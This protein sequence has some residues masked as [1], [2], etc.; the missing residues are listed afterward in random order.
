MSNDYQ[1]P[2][3]EVEDSDEDREIL[4]EATSRFETIQ[5][6]D[7]DNRDNYKADTKFVYSPGN[8][9]PD[10]VRATRTQWKE[11][12]LEFNQLK[13][14]VAQ[15]VNDQRQNRP[16][17]RIHPASGE[18]SEEVAEILQGLI[19]GI[20][21]QSNAEACY[22]NAFQ[23]AVA[24]NRGA[25]RIYSEYEDENSFNQRLCIKPIN[26]M[27]SVWADLNYQQP[28][29]SD[30]DFVFVTEKYTKTEFRNKFPKAQEISWDAVD[31]CWCDGKDTI[32]VADYYRRVCNKR[33]M[34]L[35]SDGAQG[36]KDEMPKPPEGVEIVREREVEHYTVQWFTLAGGQQILARYDW[37]GSIIPVVIVPG[38]DFIID[39]K[40]VYQSLT[41]HARDAQSMLN[42]GM[43]QQAIHLA[44]SPRAPWVAAE[45]Q[46]EGYENIWRDANTRNYSVLPY[47]PTSIDGIVVP[48]PQRT[49]PTMPDAG[50]IQFNQAMT[51]MIKSTIGMYEQSLGQR[52]NEQSGK[53]ILA[54]ERQ[55]DT[56][57]FNYSDNL[58]RGIA[59][60][61]RILVEAIP[62]Y[63]DTARIVQ[64][65]GPDETQK[66][67]EIN[68]TM[69]D[70]SN[71]LQAI[72][73]NDV[74]IGRYAVTCQAGPS[75]ATKK[76]ET[77]DKLMELV[78]AF[79]P[80][81]EVAG[82]VV[83]KALDIPD[84]DVL[85]ERLKL[86]L[87]PQVQQA[88][89]AKKNGQKPLD[90]QVMQAMQ[91]KDEQLQ[92]AVET[93]GKM[94]EEIKTLRSGSEEKLQ[95]A[96]IDAQIKIQQ[97]ELDAQTTLQKAQIDAQTKLQVAQIDAETK[98]LIAGLTTPPELSP[99]GQEVPAQELPEPEYSETPEEDSQFPLA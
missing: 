61:G 79:P 62:T 86:V 29:G 13:Q 39:G 69:P 59:L 4:E 64:I 42:F 91:Q 12:C 21:Y 74:T 66:M 99:T 35:M 84:A 88:E 22:D 23:S 26:D 51:S 97:S 75:Y 30:R 2:E 82:D 6:D 92:M 85:S 76:Q 47:K 80:I 1:S 32:I 34:V 95:A 38:E 87:P 65:I 16:G 45:G 14:F 93:M 9:W 58:A 44:L 52:G 43:T 33:T 55:G 81:A 77:A 3:T 54:R 46:I 28:D 96:Q 83:V 18:A 98:I 8:Q 49:P 41:T 37:P 19:R 72:K 68:Q 24:G 5:Q 15:V 48:P 94:E 56:A 11:M 27:L 40:R 67:V 78:Q 53:A 10:D 7:R 90:P 60:T 89:E 57:T 70:P 31:D 25:W 71:P 36:Y 20:E 50:W 73:E 63:Y 17:V